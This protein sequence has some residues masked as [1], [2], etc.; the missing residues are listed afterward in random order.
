M[1]TEPVQRKW[2]SERIIFLGGSEVAGENERR[3]SVSQFI[4]VDHSVCTGCRECEVVCSLFHFGECNPE[5]SAIRVIRREKEGLVFSLPLVCQQCDRPA[6]I[7]ACPVEAL[8]RE[9]EPNVLTVDHEACTGCGEC[10]DACPGG[11]IFM[12]N[13]R[14]VVLSC[15]L[16]GGQPQCVELCHS[17]CLSSSSGDEKE[18]ME[19]VKSLGGILDSEG[20]RECAPGKGGA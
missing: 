10:I 12:D 17:Y 15:D 13:R 16:C 2:R 6:C 19:R 7:E 14:N 20:L 1:T 5:R 3:L 9:G 4:A 8:S 18:E 11:C